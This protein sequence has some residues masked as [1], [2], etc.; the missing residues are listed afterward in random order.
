MR[1][2]LASAF[3][4]AVVALAACNNP[5]T[6]APAKLAAV[7]ALPKPSLPPW[8]ASVSPIGSSQS[9]AQVRVIFAK[10]VTSL[11]SL[12][13][14]GPRQV[15]DRISIEPALRGHFVVLTPRL[16]GFVAEQALP[17]GTRVRVTLHAGLR[18]LTGDALAHD[19]AWTFQTDNLA[20][21]DLPS[22][23]N[24]SDSPSAKPV[25]A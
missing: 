20:F 8:I 10:P 3:T 9:L 22:E 21:S 7:E 4:A 25:P 23:S 1:L 19:L 6:P 11:Q 13:G 17:I 16:V 5:S 18:D 15:L 12:S 2:L 24:D 14:D